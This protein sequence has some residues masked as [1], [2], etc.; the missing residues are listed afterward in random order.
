MIQNH[1][2]KVCHTDLDNRQVKNL[3]GFANLWVVSILRNNV[4]S[5]S[6]VGNFFPFP[7]FQQI[8]YLKQQQFSK[9]VSVTFNQIDLINLFIFSLEMVN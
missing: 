1:K 3:S 8:H 9:C 2:D 5:Q 6:I 7:C 4:S